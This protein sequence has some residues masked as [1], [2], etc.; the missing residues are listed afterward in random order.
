MMEI[1]EN[2]SQTTVDVIEEILLHLLNAIEAEN[3]NKK[4]DIDG[5]I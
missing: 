1:D 2:A 4:E 5:V 3:K